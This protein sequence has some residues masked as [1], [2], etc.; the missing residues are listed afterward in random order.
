MTEQQKLIES[1]EEALEA[2]KQGRLQWNTDHFTHAKFV[3][4]VATNEVRIVSNWIKNKLLCWKPTEY[5]YVT[6]ESSRLQEWLN[7]EYEVRFF[8]DESWVHPSQCGHK[9]WTPER[10]KEFIADDL[11]RR[12]KV[13]GGG[14]IELVEAKTNDSDIPVIYLRDSDLRTTDSRSIP[15]FGFDIP[16]NESERRTFKGVI[17]E[18]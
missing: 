17:H 11:L 16:I 10:I 1:V 9:E 6:M 13:E 15:S 4:R 18:E 2:E 3:E 12:K 8:A 5:E 14:E 7:G